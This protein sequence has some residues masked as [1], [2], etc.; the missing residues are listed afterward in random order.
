MTPFNLFL[1]LHFLLWLH[2][3]F[4]TQTTLISKI[5]PIFY[6]ATL[7]NQATLDYISYRII[8][9]YIKLV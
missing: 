2:F 5:F 7:E 9:Y 4:M 3:M 6:E 8:V 1:W